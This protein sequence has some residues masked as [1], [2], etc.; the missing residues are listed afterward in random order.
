MTDTAPQ[1]DDLLA[2]TESQLAQ[3]LAECDEILAAAR[4]ARPPLIIVAAKLAEQVRQM[5]QLRARLV[6]ALE[7]QEA[8]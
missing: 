5:E 4:A 6:R 1:L 2:C 8:A 3:M 7:I